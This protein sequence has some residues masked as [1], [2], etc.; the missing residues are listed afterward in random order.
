LARCRKNKYYHFEI[1]AGFNIKLWIGPSLT[2]QINNLKKYEK[3][4]CDKVA[5]A[6]V[7]KPTPSVI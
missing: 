1:S 6:V 7:A 5:Q 2:N 3:R 4:L